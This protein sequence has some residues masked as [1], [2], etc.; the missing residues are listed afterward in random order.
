MS[1]EEQLPTYG[2]ITEAESMSGAELPTY[3]EISKTGPMNNVAVIPTTDRETEFM[4]K[5]DNI[6]AGCM[7]ALLGILILCVIVYY[8]A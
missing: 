5:G 2:E 8:V 6:M 1:G 3:D 7:A 4:H